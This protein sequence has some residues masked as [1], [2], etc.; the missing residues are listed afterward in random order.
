M[1]KSLFMKNIY[2]LII[3]IFLSCEEENSTSSS[4]DNIEEVENGFISLSIEHDGQT[5][6]YFTYI[7]EGNNESNPF[8]VLLIFTV[9]VEMQLAKSIQLILD[10]LLT[11]LNLFWYTLKDFMVIGI[12]HFL[13]IQIARIPL[14]IMDL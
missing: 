6:R 2:F 14:M 1:G 3:I 7:P 4:K 11:L 9:A 8:P 12:C 10:R 13:V 5:R